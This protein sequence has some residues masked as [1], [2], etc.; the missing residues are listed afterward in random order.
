MHTGK[1]CSLVTRKT[2][3]AKNC[4]NILSSSIHIVNSRERIRTGFHLPTNLDFEKMNY[5]YCRKGIV[6]FLIMFEPLA[7]RCH[8]DICTSR[9]VETLGREIK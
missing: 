9:K 4:F 2:K 7:E 1:T 6:D 8:V 5:E 3:L